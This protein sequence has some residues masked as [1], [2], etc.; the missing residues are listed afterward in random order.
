MTKVKTV[1]KKELSSSEPVCKQEIDRLA[2]FIMTNLSE[3]IRDESA[4]EVAIRLLKDYKVAKA[5]I[6][7][8]TE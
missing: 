7:E 3:E 4:V 8:Y 1:P 6:E 2:R 5:I